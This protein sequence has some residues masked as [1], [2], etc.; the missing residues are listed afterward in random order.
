MK[1]LCTLTAVLLAL[2]F[3]APAGAQRIAY[4]ERTPRL[5][6]T[7]WLGDAEP[8]QAPYT[9]IEFIRSSSTPCVESCRKIK[10]YIDNTDRPMRVIFITQEQ[11]GSV[12]RRIKDCMGP[13]IG[14]AID[15]SGRLFNEFNIQYV[16]FG[17]IVDSRRRAVW[18]GNPL[19]TDNAFLRKITEQQ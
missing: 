3:A 1:P 8:A 2:M 19:T 11:P 18:F 14:I 5:K 17:V 7:R 13:Y 6:I 15:E 12:D 4:R 9:Y 16:P 10:R